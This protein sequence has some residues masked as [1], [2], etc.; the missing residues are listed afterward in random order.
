MEN[1]NKQFFPHLNPKFLTLNSNKFRLP[2][3]D[4]TISLQNPHKKN[5]LSASL[6]E[7]NLKFLLCNVPWLIDFTFIPQS[8]WKLFL[9]QIKICMALYQQNHEKYHRNNHKPFESG[10]TKW[11]YVCREKWGIFCS[12]FD[13]VIVFLYCYFNC[14]DNKRRKNKKRFDMNEK[15]RIECY[16]RL[17]FFSFFV[18][19]DSGILKD[20]FK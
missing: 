4:S 9:I 18:D 3:L 2:T 16:Q 1:A 8:I 11:I 10:L 6:F 5:Y 15:K 7:Y 17:K 12:F 14:F 20:Q 13:I 19:F